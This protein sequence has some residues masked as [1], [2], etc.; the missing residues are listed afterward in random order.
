MICQ[1]FHSQIKTWQETGV[2]PPCK[3]HHHMSYTKARQ[4][5]EAD[6]AIFISELR[7]IVMFDC[8]ERYIWQGRLSGGYGVMQLV[9]ISS[10]R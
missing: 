8:V 4:Q 10:R 6:N 2:R 5:V 1:L 3:Y 7:A 9:P